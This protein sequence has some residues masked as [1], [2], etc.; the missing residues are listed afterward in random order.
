VIKKLYL[1]IHARVFILLCIKF[2]LGLEF[3]FKILNIKFE[4][5]NIKYKKR[6]LHLPLW[7]VASPVGPL[8]SRSRRPI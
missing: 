2:E 4:T 6:R 8:N 3:E 1:C 7:A 5:E